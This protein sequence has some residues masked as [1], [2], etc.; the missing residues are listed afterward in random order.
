MAFIPS[1]LR[2]ILSRL[3]TA[4]R[5][6]NVSNFL[7]DDAI[8]I[9]QRLIR[10]GA[11]PEDFRNRSQTQQVRLIDGVPEERLERATMPDFQQ[12]M[13]IGLNKCG[14]DQRTFQR[15]TQLW[16]REKENI[17]QMTVAELREN[18]NCP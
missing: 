14:N 13:S 9:V 16:N 15:L 2:A 18:L 8:P 17:Q 7:E 4:R 11:L 1:V 6:Q 10:E 12:F 3:A 5:I